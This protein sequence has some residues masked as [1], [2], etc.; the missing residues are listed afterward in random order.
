MSV[1]QELLLAQV[2]TVGLT[3]LLRCAK[4][5]FLLAGTTSAVI[6]NHS[7]ADLC[8][9]IWGC[10]H[11]VVSGRSTPDLRQRCRWQLP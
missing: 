11:S 7:S 5:L 2:Y 9:P 10:G 6:C 4:T 1:A 8:I 3:F